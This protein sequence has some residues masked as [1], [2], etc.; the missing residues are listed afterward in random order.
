MTARRAQ[1]DGEGLTI[2]PA[3]ELR[4]FRSIRYSRATIAERGLPSLIA[5]PDAGPESAAPENIARLTSGDDPVAAAATLQ[6]WIAGGI[7]E[8]ERRPGL[9]TYRQTFVHEGAT[10][11]R[12][13]LVGLVRLAEPSKDRLLRLEEPDPAAR[14][15]ALALLRSLKA[16]FTPGLLLTR[17]PLT[18]SLA[19]TR[20]PDLTALDASG[21]RHDAYRITDFAAHVELQGLVKNAEA[22][23]A[24]GEDLFEAALE[25]SK[26]PAAV[27]FGG[28][29]YKLCVLVDGESPALVV[30]PVHRLLTGMTDWNPAHLVYAASDFFETR[31]YSSTA[32][33]LAALNDLSRLRPTFVL[34]APPAKPML[35]V[36]RDRP[37]A[38]PW[39]EDRSE[40][41]RRLDVAAIDVALLSR[42]LAA[43][44]AT[45]A[46][47]GK[48]T[49]TSDT[50]AALSAVETG[51]AQAAILLRPLPFP[52]IE[53]IAHSGE[54]LPRGAASFHPK[55]FAGLFGFS[56]EDP[57]Y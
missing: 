10:L 52:E 28:A 48:L 24:E 41:W 54:R 5:P 34:V 18:R 36:L 14:E 55:L 37:E 43:E 12:D 44:P 29:K 22:I 32:D 7:L 23:L 2:P 13:A 38:L 17:A 33:A 39:P 8:K 9:W 57:V 35:F 6:S 53:T 46:R 19:T 56:L 40:A 16:D 26:D 1:D 30:R 4:P 47:D 51:A 25:Y 31:E 3:V 20:R 27:K 42:L 21:V 15:R 50:A 49:F 45:L 11:V